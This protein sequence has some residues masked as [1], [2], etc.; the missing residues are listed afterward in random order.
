MPVV[1]CDWFGQRPPTLEELKS[2]AASARD[3]ARDAADAERAERAARRA[4]ELAKQAGVRPECALP[5]TA[6]V[7]CAEIAGV[8]HEARRF[9]TRADERRRL[10]ELASSLRARAYRA[11]RGMALS[12]ASLPPSLH[13]L[14]AAGLA[15]AGQSK[16]ALIE[17]EGLKDEQAWCGDGPLLF[18]TL[19]GVILAQNGMH[20]LAFEE[21]DRAARDLPGAQSDLRGPELAAWIHVALAGLHWQAGRERDADQ[22]L[23]RSLQLWPNSPVAVYLTGERLAAS[24]ERERAAASLE[25]A[26]AGTPS[27]AF[28][29]TLAT[30]ARQLRDGPGPLEPLVFDRAFLWD[31][32]A[33]SLRLAAHHSHA[34]ERLDVALT[35]SPELADRVLRSIPGLAEESGRGPA[36]DPAQ[37]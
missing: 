1:G 27:E 20:E 37:R 3:E 6:P 31:T 28:A 2:S 34:A 14:L 5:A 10:A 7:V 24:G 18:R 21:L 8:A 25:A 9:A 16:L 12:A 11:G 13:W 29:R 19:H 30:R 33:L 35:A 26:A 17:I 36:E 4:E 22:E 15:S 23:A 32:L